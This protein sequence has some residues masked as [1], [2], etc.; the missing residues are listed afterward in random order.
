M[1]FDLYLDINYKYFQDQ[2]KYNAFLTIH[3]N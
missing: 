3:H 2:D 1:V